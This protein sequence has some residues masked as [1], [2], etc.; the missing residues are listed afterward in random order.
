MTATLHSGDLEY[1]LTGESFS[2]ILQQA[3]R[4]VRVNSLEDYYIV[5]E[6]RFVDGLHRRK[7]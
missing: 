6:P 5:Y 7:K 3:H 1:P 2:D 4:E